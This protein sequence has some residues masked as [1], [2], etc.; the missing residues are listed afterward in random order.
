MCVVSCIHA[1]FLVIWA[2]IYTTPAFTRFHYSSET[3]IS[4]TDPPS[5]LHLLT[6]TQTASAKFSLSCPTF[7]N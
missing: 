6:V 3:L 5:H 4:A 7:Y 2:I 1:S